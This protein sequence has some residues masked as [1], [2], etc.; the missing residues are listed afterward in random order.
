MA[1]INI[2]DQK[3]SFIQKNDLE[4]LINSDEFEDHLLAF[5]MNQDP[6]TE[7]ISAEDF[8]VKYES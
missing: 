7:I 6:G 3:Y 1:T 2:Q 4:N 8:L 5:H